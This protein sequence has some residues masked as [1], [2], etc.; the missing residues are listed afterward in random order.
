MLQGTAELALRVWGFTGDRLLRL[1]AR[2]ARDHPQIPDGYLDDAISHLAEIG[3]RAALE[4][5]PALAPNLNYGTVDK[6]FEAF[7]YYRMRL[8]LIDWLRSTSNG[9]EFGRNGTVGRERLGVDSDDEPYDGFDD[10]RV[11]S[12]MRERFRRAA[13]LSGLTIDEWA[14]QAMTIQS[15]LQLLELAAAPA[16]S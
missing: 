6:K 15:D 7:A 12:L 11:S 14:V 9:N 4:F 16:K 13:E 1:A 5:D 10:V 8:R 2:A 3:M